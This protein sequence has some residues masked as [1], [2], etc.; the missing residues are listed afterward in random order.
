MRVAI[1]G[2][3]PGGSYLRRL[4]QLRRPEVEVDLYDVGARTKCGLKP[5]GWG[6]SLPEFAALCA[7]VDTNPGE[8]ILSVYDQVVAEGM[9]I[10]AK[11]AIID[12]PAFVRHMLGRTAIRIPTSELKEY[13]IVVD[14]T[15][16]RAYL[17]YNS[18]NISYCEAVEAR[19]RLRSS[20]MPTAFMNIEGGY[21]WAVP[22]GDGTAHIGSL[23]IWGL[24]VAKQG[25]K[26]TTQ[27]VNAGSTLCTCS[28]PITS[29]GPILP[30]TIGNVW[31]LGESIGL[32]D[33]V[34]GVGITA[35]MDSARMMVDN[36]SKPGDYQRQILKKYGY[37]S[38][39]ARTVSKIVLG[40]MPGIKDIPLLRKSAHLAGIYPNPP[41]ITKLS[42][43]A[44]II[45]KN[46]HN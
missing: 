39:L 17:G 36:W 18:N 7:E 1:M 26:K 23:S 30:F 31:G 25:M 29:F 5:C 19:V 28:A 41:E 3:G 37:M 46:R 2:C 21:S 11:L 14:A 34:T 12:K 4:L 8:F 35:A 32:V 16:R 27:E 40:H 43:V 9:R 33:P 24:D 10:S 22:L 13:D 38:K 20:M 45:Q 44:V 6:V 42:G 15:G